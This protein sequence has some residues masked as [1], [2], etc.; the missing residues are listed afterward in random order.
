M[1]P[2]NT[3]AAVFELPL[4]VGLLVATPVAAVQ[5]TATS[6]GP[7]APLFSAFL[8]G[9]TLAPSAL[10]HLEPA[11]RD[12]VASRFAGRLAYK[13][14]LKVPPAAKGIERT[15][16]SK[17]QHFEAM[18]ATLSGRPGTGNEAV[19]VTREVQLSYEWEGYSDGP[20]REAMKAEEYLG[21]HPD[22]VLAPALDLFIL[23]RYRCAFEA[24][25]FNKD[26]QEQANSAAWYRAAWQRARR[27]QDV[28]VQALTRDIDESPYVYLETK[29]HPRTFK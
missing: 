21:R 18:L 6:P 9:G 27:V 25:T 29:L 20:I 28:V 2:R 8:W 11:V 1:R 7:D 17:Q 19:A 26:E 3:L 24:A 13:P 5:P 12:A 10:Q 4:L 16:A 23:H 15:L 14:I 22:T